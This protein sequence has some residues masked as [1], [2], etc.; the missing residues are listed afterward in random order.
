LAPPLQSFHPFELAISDIGEEGGNEGVKLEQQL[1]ITENGRE[2]LS[3]FPFES[4][5]LD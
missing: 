5:L 1:L 4:G 2:L 3:L